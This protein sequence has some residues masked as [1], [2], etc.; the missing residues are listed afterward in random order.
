MKE[1]KGV[2]IDSSQSIFRDGDYDLVFFYNTLD[3]NSLDEQALKLAGEIQ[4]NLSPIFGAFYTS[5]QRNKSI[6]I[7]I[8]KLIHGKDNIEANISKMVTTC[9]RQNVDLIFTIEG[10]NY[11][12]IADKDSQ[13]Y[14]NEDL[15]SSK[16]YSMKALLDFGSEL[17][18]FIAK[19]ESNTYR[20]IDTLDLGFDTIKG[21]EYWHEVFSDLNNNKKFQNLFKKAFP[22]YIF[23]RDCIPN[24]T[25]HYN[26]IKITNLIISLYDINIKKNSEQF[27]LYKRLI[28]E[29]NLTINPINQKYQHHI[30]FKNSSSAMNM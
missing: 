2:I 23:E 27:Q 28:I 3:I 11:K 17:E 18:S 8:I 22:D 13:N 12:I 24:L 14:I 16:G 19:K 25:N 6:N 21:K 10:K 1:I 9:L 20:P 15:K 4:A 7:P 5:F 26:P 29:Y 30:D